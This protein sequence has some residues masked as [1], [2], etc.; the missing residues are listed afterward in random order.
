METPL[1]RLPKFTPVKWRARTY[2]ILHNIADQRTRI[3]Y[4]LNTVSWA[5]HRLLE[6]DQASGAMMIDRDDDQHVHLASMFQNGISVGS[7]T[8]RLDDRIKFFGMSSNN[9]SH[10]SSAVDVTLGA[11][12]Y[13]VNTAGGDGNEVV[14]RD[15]FPPLAKLLWSIGNGENRRIGGYGYHARPESVRAPSYAEKYSELAA[16]L[17]RFAGA[18]TSEDPDAE[19]A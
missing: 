15:I 19:K 8:A 13:C 2:V 16:T 10:L 17:S 1:P 6:R 7:R 11:F 18:D 12:R 14:A 9:A 5:Y 4:A 3:P